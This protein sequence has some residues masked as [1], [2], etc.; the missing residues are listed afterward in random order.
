MELIDKAG[1]ID[2]SG[3]IDGSGRIDTETSAMLAGVL[4]CT[5]RIQALIEAGEWLGAAEA[6]VERQDL[7]MELC[8]RIEPRNCPPALVAALAELVTVNQAMLG[9]VERR[10]DALYRDA[11]T[12]GVGR[13]AV[14]AY[15]A[16]GDEAERRY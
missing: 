5:R 9:A 13:K 10:Q 1:A 2:G 6:D 14:A 16:V 4:E 7:L 3:C 12:I 8:G 11:E 15:G